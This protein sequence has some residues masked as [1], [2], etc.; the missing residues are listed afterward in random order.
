MGGEFSESGE[1]SNTWVPVIYIYFQS[2]RKI[3]VACFSFLD[4]GGGLRIGRI[5]VEVQLV[6]PRLVRR[7][8]R[9]LVVVILLEVVEGQLGEGTAA[10]EANIH[11]ERPAQ[12]RAESIPRAHSLKPCESR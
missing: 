7:P 11:Y 2:D 6:R 3:S 4:G 10:G 1:P 8:E 12:L 5:V 9:G